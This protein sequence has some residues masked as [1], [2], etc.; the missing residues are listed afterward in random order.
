MINKY[1]EE[2]TGLGK[3]S[4]LS[5]LRTLK[6]VL[7]NS[8]EISLQNR[9][10][11]LRSEASGRYSNSYR[12]V[13]FTCSASSVSWGLAQIIWPVALNNRKHSPGHGRVKTCHKVNPSKAEHAF[14][15]VQN[16]SAYN[17]KSTIDYFRLP[18]L[19]LQKMNS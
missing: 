5:L 12:L 2:E 16:A 13:L 9:V 14:S 3:V 19:S 17:T 18:L 10:A 1:E 6:L 8:N 7:L 4:R 15:R 11:V